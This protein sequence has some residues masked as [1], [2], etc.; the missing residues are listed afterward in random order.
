MI[1]FLHI[2]VYSVEEE[3]EEEE[4]GEEDEFVSVLTAE[5]WTTTWKLVTWRSTF[6]SWR[7]GCPAN[8]EEE[9]TES[10]YPPGNGSLDE[11][12]RWSC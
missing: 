9:Q 12:A 11:R 2:Y 6:Q 3:N 8:G 5:K 1:Y 10:C 7:A 4:K